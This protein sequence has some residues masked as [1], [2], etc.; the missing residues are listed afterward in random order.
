MKLHLKLVK[1]AFIF[2]ISTCREVFSKKCVLKKPKA[3]NCVKKETPTQMFS[4]EF[5]EIFKNTFSHDI[6]LGDGQVTSW[7]FFVTVNSSYCAQTWK[8]II[9]LVHSLYINISYCDVLNEWS[10]TDEINLWMS[11][12]FS[13]FKNNFLI[14]DGTF[15]AKNQSK[16][17][18]FV[19]TRR[20]RLEMFYKIGV[21]KNFVTVTGKHLCRSLFFNVVGVLRTATLLKK[22]LQLRR[23]PVNFT[24]FLKI[25]FLK[26]TS[27]DCFLKIDYMQIWS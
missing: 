22:K 13:F 26:N 4:W 6:N 8:E 18:E 16:R 5:C 19:K 11:I 21:L 20:S 2:S 7:N 14:S 12:L 3:C 27:G 24:R 9:L 23:F 15:F 25:L 17:P 10:V 1:Y